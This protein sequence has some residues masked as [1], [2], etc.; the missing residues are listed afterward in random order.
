MFKMF[1]MIKM[2]KIIKIE[3]RTLQGSRRNL[4]SRIKNQG[5]SFQE[6]RSRLKTQ[7][8]RIK[9]RLNEDKCEKVFSKIE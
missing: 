8:S 9:I 1:K 3:S 4:T 2:Y 7:D 5:S 6:S